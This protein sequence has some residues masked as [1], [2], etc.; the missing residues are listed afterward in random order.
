MKIFKVLKKLNNMT[1]S[2]E[3]KQAR[4]NVSEAFHV[5]NHLNKR[6]LVLETTNLLKNFVKDYDLKVVLTIGEKMLI[7]QVETLEKLLKEY[8]IPFPPRPPKKLQPVNIEFVEDRYVFRRVFRGIQSFLPVHVMAF[9]HST[10]P[11]I[12]ETFRQF[13]N[14]ELE[15]YDKFLRYGE[16]KGFLDSPPIYKIT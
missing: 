11:D 12:R 16:I 13:F 9:T 7:K 10:S 2:T 15:T 4:I 5:W 8:G 3:E 6:Y 14:D 1:A